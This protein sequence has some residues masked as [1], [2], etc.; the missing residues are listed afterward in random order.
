[1]KKVLCIVMA[2]LMMLPLC[3]M[4]EDLALNYSDAN[5]I[6]SQGVSEEEGGYRI[7]PGGYI[8]FPGVD[9]TGIKSI[10]VNATWTAHYNGDA[11]AV[12]IDNP[13][14]GDL[15]GY[16]TINSNFENVFY[17]TLKET[18]GVHDLYLYSSYGTD[19]VVISGITLSE[20]EYTVEKAP[21]VSDDYI[22]DNYHDTWAAVD[23]VGRKVADYGE[24][25]A[26]KEGQREVGML[27]WNWH[28]TD[29]A[30]PIIIHEVIDEHPEAKDDFYH[31]GWGTGTV[32]YWDES[33]FGFY[34]SFDYWVYRRHAEMLA[35]IGVDAIFFD[36]T[37]DDYIFLTSLQTLVSAFRDAKKNGVAVPKIAPF[38]SWTNYDF[39]IKQLKAIYLNCFVEEDYSDVWYYRDGKPMLF[40]QA[41]LAINSTS[42]KEE[43]ATLINECKDF[44]SYR[45][46]GEWNWLE[47]YPQV[48]RGTVGDRVEFIDVGVARNASYVADGIWCFSDEYAKGRSYT[49]AFGEDY[50]A[51][52]NHEGY[53][54]KEQISRALDVDPTFVMIC[55]WNELKT[56]PAPA[57]PGAKLFVN[58]FVD[59]FDDENSR[60][61]EPVK[62][63]LKDD[64]YNLTADFIRK[65]KG[66]RPVPAASEEVTINVNGDASQWNSVG[67]LYI[68]DPVN[69]TRADAG[70]KGTFYT[71]GYQNSIH[72]MKV[73]R[74]SENYYFYVETV[75]DIVINGNENMHLYLNI[76]RNKATG[77]EGYDYAVNTDGLGTISAWSNEDSAWKKLEVSLNY[78]VK[79]N[80]LQLEIPKELVEADDKAV[81]EFKWA[82]SA[83][84]DEDFM[85]LYQYGSVAP[86]GR[87]NYVYTEIPEVTA[88]SE[89]REALIDT[90]ILKEGA[91]KY[92]NEGAILDVYETDTR[93]KT[94]SK[95][96]TLYLPS[97]AYEDILGYGETKVYKNPDE[98]IVMI[99]THTLEDNEIMNEEFMYSVI[100]SDVICYNGQYRTL[101]AESYEKDGILFLP[102]TI[103]ESFGYKITETEGLTVIHKDEAD[104]E[105]VSTVAAYIG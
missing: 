33:L 98:T 80:V 70:L 12:R 79:G 92:I 87:F 53:F 90:V 29:W 46:V 6:K 86:L 14:V 62:G 25:G 13:T 78:S 104:M 17:A 75:S 88:T 38:T 2:I 83:K 45:S 50:R 56:T 1:M 48:A 85:N 7:A 43:D 77:W 103:L 102:V 76:D 105:T 11:F 97:I 72:K 54:M 55:G 18:Q 22:V 66:V 9:L 8:C 20:N 27:Y 65:Y 52:A 73:A 58:G 82:D 49:E 16:V 59:L 71:A 41:K 10:R 93:I 64:Y 21:T 39:A 89:Q 74:N 35:N 99:K 51:E 26:V 96:G 15:L 24:A 57:Y 42:M 101:E 63:D 61:I 36:D 100:G 19:L 23:N 69:Y 60:D 68:T 40:G 5:L 94:V 34:D 4:A 47:D 81:F 37:N 67:P 30:P 31:T 32:K 84:E 28:V 3:V 95:N 91:G 44:F